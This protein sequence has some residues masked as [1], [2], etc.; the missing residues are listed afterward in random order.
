MSRGA[1]CAPVVIEQSTEP[2]L[3]MNVTATESW[4]TLNQGVLETL[5]VPLSVVVRNELG[6][7]ASEMPFAQQNHPVETFLLD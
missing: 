6:H 5:M 4:R 7:R 1:R 3:S 2:L